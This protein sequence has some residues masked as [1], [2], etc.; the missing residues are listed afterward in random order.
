MGKINQMKLLNL[1]VLIQ[2]KMINGKLFLQ[3]IKKDMLPLLYQFMNQ[4]KFIY[5][6][7]EVIIKILWL[8]KLKNM[9]L[10][11]IFG[12]KLIYKNHMNGTQL[13]FVQ[14]FKLLKE[15]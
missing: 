4:K 13:K 8:N 2:Y 1:V 6:V 10:N 14:G 11:L 7:E 12:K 15:N 9:I 3:L 5:L